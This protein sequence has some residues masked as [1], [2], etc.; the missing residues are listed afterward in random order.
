MCVNKME[1]NIYGHENIYIQNDIF[2][3][4]QKEG[5]IYQI[6]KQCVF[7]QVKI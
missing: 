7:E 6:R 5:D 4:T 3:G 2:L 1:E